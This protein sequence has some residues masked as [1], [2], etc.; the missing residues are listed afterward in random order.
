MFYVN[1]NIFYNHNQNIKNG[2]QP[3]KSNGIKQFCR[4]QIKSSSLQADTFCATNSMN[5][6]NK[7]T[8]TFTG[9]SD[10]FTKSANIG[11]KE[12]ASNEIQK[13][14]VKPLTAEEF[15]AKKAE[16]MQKAKEFES[17][18]N[19]D[20]NNLNEHNIFVLEAIVKKSRI[21]EQQKL[22]R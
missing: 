5:H 17:L 19:I 9:S 15:Q 11:T 1:M 18:K 22:R 21:N 7:N 13:I 6:Q 3:T 2:P 8:P 12:K 4:S 16:L 14:E 20:E 10:F